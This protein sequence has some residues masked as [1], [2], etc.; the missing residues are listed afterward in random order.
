MTE[1]NSI[2]PISR[3]A[4]ASLVLG[5]L[6]VPLQVIAG[7]P[8]IA[9]GVTSLREINSSEGR[10]SGRWM[11]VVGIAMGIF[12]GVLDLLAIGAY[13]IY[14]ARRTSALYACKNN[15]RQI[16]LAVTA[17]H[18]DHKFFPPGTV[19]NAGLLPDQRLSWLVSLLP[20]YIDMEASSR[21]LRPQDTSLFDVYSNIDLARSWDAPTNRDAATR[22]LGQFICPSHPAFT[23]EPSPGPTYYV[24][25]SGI[26]VDAALLRLEVR[27]CGF[28]GYDRKITQTDVTRGLSNTTIAIETEWRNGPWAKGGFATVRGLDPSD[29]PYTGAGRPFGGLHPGVTNILHADASVQAF[30]DRGSATVFIAGATIRVEAVERPQP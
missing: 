29:L 9:L 2:P 7:L 6:A 15:L 11:C 3:K 17:Y 21:K 10:S 14:K 28:F 24:G 26:G 18:V 20:Y 25:I 8:A 19:P 30:D 5:L 1:P 22:Q 4:L 23:E 16:G 12:V 13:A 27:N